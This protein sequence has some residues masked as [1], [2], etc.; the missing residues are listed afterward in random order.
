MIN[1]MARAVI[2]ASGTNAGI[3]IEVILI[4]L[5]ISIGSCNSIERLYIVEVPG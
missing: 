4:M 2:V 3:K 1:Q 5:G